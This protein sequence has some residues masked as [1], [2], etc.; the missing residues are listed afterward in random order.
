[1]QNHH[2]SSLSVLLRTTPTQKT[3]LSEKWA[4]QS[5]LFVSKRKPATTLQRKKMKEQ[6]DFLVKTVDAKL[7]GYQAELDASV[8]PEITG[9]PG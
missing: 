8:L 3:H 2:H 7:D 9:M 4:L 1:L 6:L 5:P